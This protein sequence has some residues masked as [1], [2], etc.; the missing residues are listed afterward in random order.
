MLRLQE[1]AMNVVTRNS[2]SLMAEP[3]SCNFLTS[4]VLSYENCGVLEV[5]WE[6]LV[7][8]FEAAVA[9]RETFNISPKENKA[10]NFV[11]LLDWERSNWVQSVPQGQMQVSQ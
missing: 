2:V 3:P 8:K 9:A 7:A 11:S 5:M 4:V 10:R 1:V 6:G